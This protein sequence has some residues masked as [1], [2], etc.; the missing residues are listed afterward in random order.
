MSLNGDKFEHMRVGK[1]LQ[2]VEYT[3]SDPSGAPIVEK[4]HIKDLGVFISNN[5]SWSKQIQTVVSKSR[6]MVGWAL[7]T[8]AT[9]EKKC[10]ITIWNSQIRPIIDYC[11]PL[12]SPRPWNYKEIDFL[13][14]TLRSFTRQINGMKDY[15]YAQRLKSL[16]MYSIQRCHERYKII[17]AYKIKEKVPNISKNNGLQFSMHGRRG[18]WCEIPTFPLHHNK[19]GRARDDSFTLTTCNLWNSLPKHIRNINGK[20]VEYFKKKLDETL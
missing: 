3:Y 1:N 4:D 7:R 17:Y 11:S 13:E 8:F 20:S 19:A 2:Q 10:M 5:L 14:E 9:R 15:D 18:L 16:K 12:W 6:A